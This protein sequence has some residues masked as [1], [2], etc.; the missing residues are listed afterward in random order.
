LF[1]NCG[2]W[3]Y[4]YATDMTMQYRRQSNFQSCFSC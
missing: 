3:I 4:I 2:W 1:L